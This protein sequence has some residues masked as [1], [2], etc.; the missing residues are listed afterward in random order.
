MH[1]LLMH[2]TSY[3]MTMR[4][5]IRGIAGIGRFSHHSR[6]QSTYTASRPT[7]IQYRDPKK[8]VERRPEWLSQAAAAEDVPATPSTSAPTGGFSEFGIDERLLVSTYLFTYNSLHALYLTKVLLLPNCI[9]R[10]T[11]AA[12]AS[13]NRQTSKKQPSLA[14]LPAK[15]SQFNVIQGVVKH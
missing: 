15:T 12:K 3:A 13:P 2:N 6:F 1:I 7:F 4:A 14:F 8:H 5:L 10:Q 9:Y 11:S